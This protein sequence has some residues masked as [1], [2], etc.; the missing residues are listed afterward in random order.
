MGKYKNSER[1][2]VCVSAPSEVV[3]VWCVLIGCMVSCEWCKSMEQEH[4]HAATIA[5][6]TVVKIVVRGCMYV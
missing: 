1:V 2:Y 3:V 5:R 6:A 4:C